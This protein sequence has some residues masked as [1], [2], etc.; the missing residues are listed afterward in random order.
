MKLRRTA[1]VESG[2]AVTL[3]LRVTLRCG[4][5]SPMVALEYGAVEFKARE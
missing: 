5:R 3:A 4:V 2:A 1:G